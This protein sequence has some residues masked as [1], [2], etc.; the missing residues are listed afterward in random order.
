MSVGVN[1]LPMPC[2]R[3]RVRARRARRWT[4]VCGCAALVVSAAWLWADEQ[5]A[6][7]DRLQTELQ[8][9]AA[10]RAD[11]ERQLST[12]TRARDLLTDKAR[13]LLEVRDTGRL[14]ARLDALAT[15]APDG[16][17]LTEISA[18]PAPAPPV[19]APPPTVAAAGRPPA[20]QPARRRVTDSDPIVQIAGL[21][22]SQADLSALMDALRRIDGWNQVELVHA[23][24]QAGA[25]ALVGFKLECR[26]AGAAP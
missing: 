26:R 12:A 24:S 23:G 4:I 14:A 1:L 5:S 11:L 6:E 15:G 10:G 20:T 2:R 17:V 7:R 8:V 18:R 16:I 19:V 13:A 25:D 21:A 3:R 22:R 9:R